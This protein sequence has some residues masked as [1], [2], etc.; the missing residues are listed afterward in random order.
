MSN[1]IENPNSCRVDFFKQGGKWYTTEAVIFQ[2]EDYS[3]TLI[4]DAFKNAL[5]EEVPNQYL[6]MRAICLEP[7]HQHCHPISLIWEG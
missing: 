7:Y 4:H 3:G 5:R 2:S 1:Y 6:G